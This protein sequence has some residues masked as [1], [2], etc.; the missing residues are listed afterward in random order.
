MYSD[1]DSPTFILDEIKSK[2]VTR[3]SVIQRFKK[4]GKVPTK[5]VD[6]KSWNKLCVDLI[7]PS[8][9]SRTGK[10]PLIIKSVTKIDTVIG[11]FEVTPYDDR[12]VTMIANLVETM[13]L[14]RYPWTSEITY[15]HISESLGLDFK[16]P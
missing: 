12:K 3:A 14:S 10:K 1:N 13:W 2:S 5:L 15:D 6:E 11:W 16:A 8:N 9:I 4:N 7:V